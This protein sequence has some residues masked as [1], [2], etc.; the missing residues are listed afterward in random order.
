MVEEKKVWDVIDGTKAEPTNVVQT[1]KKEKTN[2]V[3]FKII[4]QGV[5]SDLYVNIIIE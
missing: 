3:A 4:K 1:R 5:N 2:A